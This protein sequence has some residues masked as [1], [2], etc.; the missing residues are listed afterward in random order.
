M[1]RVRTKWYKAFN[2]GQISVRGSGM[3]RGVLETH[4]QKLNNLI[5]LALPLH[6]SSPILISSRLSPGRTSFM[7]PPWISSASFALE[8]Y[9][10]SFPPLLD[11]ISSILTLCLPSRTSRL[12]FAPPHCLSCPISRS[13]YMSKMNHFTSLWRDTL[14]VLRTKTHS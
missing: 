11:P 2:A 7:F 5:L 13:A 1:L 4:R 6:F 3:R 9:P 12:T 14:I 8:Y 10:L